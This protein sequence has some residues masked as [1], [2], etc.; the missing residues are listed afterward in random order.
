MC[1]STW[2][3]SCIHPRLTI[4]CDVTRSP[5]P[6]LLSSFSFYLRSLYSALFTGGCCCS[7]GR[8]L[9]SPFF[10]LP[11]SLTPS[12]GF[13]SSAAFCS[14]CGSRAAPLQMFSILVQS[15]LWFQIAELCTERSPRQGREGA[16]RWKEGKGRGWV[17]GST[18][19]G[20]SG[21]R[22]QKK[23]QEVEGKGEGKR[24]KAPNWP[25]RGRVRHGAEVRRKYGV[26]EESSR[27]RW[28][29][30][31]S[32]VGG[33]PYVLRLPLPIAR[34]PAAA[35]A[36]HL[37]SCRGLPHAHHQPLSAGQGNT[38]LGRHHCKLLCP[39]FLLFTT[40]LFL[41]SQPAFLIAWAK[42]EAST[43]ANLTKPVNHRSPYAHCS[44]LI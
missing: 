17:S 8:V 2:H 4:T 32:Q 13:L 20:H 23:T 27:V 40:I 14:I 18:V 43:S 30:Q 6:Q 10:G 7:S 41:S 36:G 11:S 15:P 39:P 34:R 22:E 29:G 31:A 5:H 3:K 16:R 19:E 26:R 21:E 37:H 25:F 9:E 1:G 28:R 44:R 33:E 38:P 24:K 12:L 35:A 42:H